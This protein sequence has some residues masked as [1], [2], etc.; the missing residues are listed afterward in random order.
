MTL[1][2]FLIFR[3]IYGPPLLLRSY[4]ENQV[5]HDHEENPK[6]TVELLVKVTGF[7]IFVQFCQVSNLPSIF[8]PLDGTPP[9]TI[10]KLTFM[11]MILCHL[12]TH[13][14]E[15]DPKWEIK[16]GSNLRRLLTT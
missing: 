11:I 5:N 7:V 3:T 9:F 12:S 6:L 8:L 4:N 1:W 2:H 13:H 15:R 14:C 16:D 10:A